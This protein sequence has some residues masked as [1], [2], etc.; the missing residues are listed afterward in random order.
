VRPAHPVVVFV[1]AVMSSSRSHRRCLDISVSCAS[2]A[3]PRIV[4]EPCL[5]FVSHSGRSRVVRGV[6]GSFVAF[7]R[8]SGHQGAGLDLGALFGGR[9]QMPAAIMIIKIERKAKYLRTLSADAP[10]ILH[11]YPDSY[12][13]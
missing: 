7:Q 1:L 3:I 11:D 4:G 5:L 6:P 10:P 2:F 12:T 8:R 13:L 9:R